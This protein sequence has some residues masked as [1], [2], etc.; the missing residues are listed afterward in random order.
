MAKC[1][2]PTHST[3]AIRFAEH[4]QGTPD[5]T[6]L[7]QGAPSSLRARFMSFT[8]RER[9]KLLGC[10]P[11]SRGWLQTPHLKRRGSCPSKLTVA[12]SPPLGAPPAEARTARPSKQATP[13]KAPPRAA[14]APEGRGP[15]R[16]GC[17]GRTRPRASCTGAS[18]A[19]RQQL[20][21]REGVFIYSLSLSPLWHI[22]TARRVQW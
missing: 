3:S 11:C 4:D 2:T 6:L 8:R 1:E 9:V 10:T 18:G 22:K 12:Q 15:C 19:F 14:S 5:A 17:S 20:A 13:T 7:P 21:L 16:R